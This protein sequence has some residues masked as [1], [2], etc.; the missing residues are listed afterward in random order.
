MFKGE[1]MID[2][3]R[4]IIT[5]E[6]LV[7]LGDPLSLDEMPLKPAGL[8]KK[9]HRVADPYI[10]AH[11]VKGKTYYCF[12]RGIEPEIYLGTAEAIYKAVMAAKLASVMLRLY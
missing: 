12:R 9:I 5:D 8:T 10:K 4:E 3:S 1:K 11:K 2:G 6:K 7:H